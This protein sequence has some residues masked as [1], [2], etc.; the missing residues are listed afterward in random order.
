MDNL[1]LPGHHHKFGS[2][3]AMK[4][5]SI[6]LCHTWTASICQDLGKDPRFKLPLLIVKF[7]NVHYLDTLQCPPLNS[8][9]SP[10]LEV[11]V[12]DVSD[13][14]L[15][16]LLESGSAVELE[17]LLESGLVVT[18][19]ELL[20]DVSANDRKNSHSQRKSGASC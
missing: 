9:N 6:G 8:M 19:E 7:P 2:K 17:E 1:G 10:E 3:I 12:D 11:S 14:E 16:E 5:M 18:L 13:A 15:E 4:T 20:D